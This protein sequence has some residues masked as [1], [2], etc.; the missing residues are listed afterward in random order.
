MCHGFNRKPYLSPRA[1]DKVVVLPV[2][3]LARVCCLPTGLQVLLR[4]R[5]S[6]LYR[7]ESWFPHIPSN[8]RRGIHR[9]VL[10]TNRLC[11]F[12][13]VLLEILYL[14][15]IF[16]KRNCSAPT[17]DIYTQ[18]SINNSSSFYIDKNA[19]FMVVS[20]KKPCRSVGENTRRHATWSS[21]FHCIPLHREFS[22]Q[23]S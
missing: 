10:P 19:T 3:S 6:V 4:I 16:Q 12:D 14:I 13:A 1:Q 7:F 8:N 15:Q 22:K 18:S 21:W 5:L 23:R 11:L 9:G 20:H 2:D 17:H